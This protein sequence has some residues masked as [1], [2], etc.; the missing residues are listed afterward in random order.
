M[1]KSSILW[2]YF[3]AVILFWGCDRTYD[4]LPEHVERVFPLEE[5]KERIYMVTDTT[6]ESNLGVEGREYVR[7]EYYDGLETDLLGREVRKVFIYNAPDSVN[8]TGQRVYNWEYVDLWTDYKDDQYAERSEGN[9]RYLLMKQPPIEDIAWNGNLFN[10]KDAETYTY[11]NIDTTLVV[12]GKTYENCVF[13]LQVPFRRTGDPG[14]FFLEEYAY[15]AYAP[16]IGKILKYRK[17]IEVQSGSTQQESRVFYE[18][19]IDHNF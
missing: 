16:D 19:L 3:L 6:Y 15:E 4:P 18:R 17:Y 14:T 13:V 1:R 10:G 9:T 2:G 5:G 8:S 11:V 12:E 7:R